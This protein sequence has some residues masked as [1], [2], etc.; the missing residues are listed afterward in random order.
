MILEFK[1]TFGLSL[2]NDDYKDLK[3]EN[4]AFIFYFWM[5]FCRG[6]GGCFKGSKDKCGSKKKILGDRGIS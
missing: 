6:C 5:Y 4:T 3:D 2:V 1:V